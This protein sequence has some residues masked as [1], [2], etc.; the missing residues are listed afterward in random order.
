MNAC[1]S[2]DKI[3]RVTL[4]DNNEIEVVIQTPSNMSYCN[5]EPCPDYVCMQVYGVVDGKIKLVRNIKGTHTPAQR[6][7]EKLEF[8]T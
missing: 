7:P 5:G 2:N 3:R 4:T 6:I 1:G 8:P